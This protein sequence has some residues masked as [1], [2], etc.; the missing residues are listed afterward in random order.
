MLDRAMEEE[1]L[2]IHCAQNLPVAMIL[3]CS[4]M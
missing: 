2:Q 1:L 4:L 3:L